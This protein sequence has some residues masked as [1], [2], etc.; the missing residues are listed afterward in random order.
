[1]GETFKYT[2]NVNDVDDV[3]NVTL[4][5]THRSCNTV[6]T[7]RDIM[8]RVGGALILSRPTSSVCHSWKL[9]TTLSKHEAELSAPCIVQSR[10]YKNNVTSVCELKNQN[11]TQN[12]QVL[13]FEL[14]S[15]KYLCTLNAVRLDCEPRRD[16][17]FF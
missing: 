11:D 6:V 5:V 1:M 2:Y 12:Y 4:S 8:S 7:S 16:C 3:V 17:P 9:S 14:S 15:P 10:T 13:P